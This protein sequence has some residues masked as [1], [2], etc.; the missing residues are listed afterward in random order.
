[1]KILAPQQ[2]GNAAQENAGAD[3]DDDG[4]DHRC[5]LGGFD[6]KPFQQQ[7]RNDSE[8]GGGAGGQQQRHAGVEQ[9]DGDHGAQHDELALG[10]VHHVGSVIDQGEA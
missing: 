8:Q 5:A 3:G 9:R 6:G 10:E 2:Q 7:A 4:G 1:M